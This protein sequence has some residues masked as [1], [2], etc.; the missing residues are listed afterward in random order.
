MDPVRIA[1]IGAGLIGARHV[2]CV[3]ACPSAVLAAV[4]DPAEEAEALAARHG[5][6]WW[7]D[8]GAML[9]AGGVDGA[10]VAAPTHLHEPLGLACVAAGMPVLLEKPISQ[11]VASAE[12]LNLAAGAAGV[13]LLVG[14]H[15]RYAP[16]LERACALVRSGVLGRL[17]GASCHW[18][19]AKPAD[20]FAQA[21]RRG[22]GGGPVLINLIHDIDLLRMLLGEIVEV[23]ALT[24]SAVREN[25]T[26]DTAAIALRFA[27]GGLGTVLLSDTAPSPWTWEQGTGESLNFPRS[28]QNALRLFGSEA[29]LE[30]PGLRLWRHDGAPDWTTPI[31]SEATPAPDVDVF[32][33]QT[34][35]F[36]EVIRGT[37]PRVSG[38]DGQ[39]SLAAT[40]AVLEA[41]RLGRSVRP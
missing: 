41:A 31:A 4:V 16:T 15:R 36:V 27:N 32:A 17:V 8:A 19:V 29:S 24:S 7:S 33:L 25:E 14:H 5:V 12:R 21:W 2:A 13:P 18:C 20:Y 30:L 6:P 34:A 38:R 26:E 37:A 23:A 22:P 11:D 3:D 28:G 10:I 40:L 35:H 39:A 1:V 9:N